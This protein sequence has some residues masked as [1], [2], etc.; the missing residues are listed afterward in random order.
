MRPRIDVHVEE[1]VLDGFDRHDGDA[2]ARALEAELARLLGDRVP[3]LRSVDSV[4]GGSVEA[5]ARGGEAALGASV[6]RGVYGGLG[7]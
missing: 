7:A 6:A 1:L 4:D 5:P 3:Q 2:V